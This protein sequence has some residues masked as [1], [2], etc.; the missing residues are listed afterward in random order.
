MTAIDGR[1]LRSLLGNKLLESIDMSHRLW[2]LHMEQ[3]LGFKPSD[4][5]LIKFCK[6]EQT[7]SNNTAWLV[8][9]YMPDLSGSGEAMAPER[10]VSLIEGWVDPDIEYPGWRDYVGSQQWDRH[11]QALL[12]QVEINSVIEPVTLMPASVLRRIVDYTCEIREYSLEEFA[13]RVGLNVTAI[14]DLLSGK[15][16]DKDKSRLNL[17]SRLLLNPDTGELIGT[18]DDLLKLG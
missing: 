2:S 11:A 1:E 12:G 5:T 3:Y 14:K 16:S 4:S 15:P 6:I 10:L 18:L 13:D 17:L 7:T 9:H 8:A